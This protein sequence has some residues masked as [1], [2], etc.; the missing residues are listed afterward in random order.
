MNRITEDGPARPVEERLK[1]LF[2]RGLDENAADH[3]AF[4][5]DLIGHLRGF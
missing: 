3:Q 5:S 1:D 2:V 4:L